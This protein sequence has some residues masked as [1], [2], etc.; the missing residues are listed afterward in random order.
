[1]LRFAPY[2]GAPRLEPILAQEETMGK[3]TRSK[4]PTKSPR[5]KKS[6]NEPENL[7]PIPAA[8]P[9]EEPQVDELLPPDEK[10]EHR[11]AQQEG[12]RFPL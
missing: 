10:R 2:G 5:V 12:T 11:R 4:A 3:Q 9:S 7:S 6:L 1:V 8:A